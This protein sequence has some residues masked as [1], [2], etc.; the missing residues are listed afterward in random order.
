MLLNVHR[1]TVVNKKKI[2]FL[3][4][5][6]QTIG[7]MLVPPRKFFGDLNRGTKKYLL[8]DTCQIPEF[9][10]QI[11]R[12]ENPRGTSGKRSGTGTTGALLHV[13]IPVMI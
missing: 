7:E 13:W 3:C 4:L 8:G 11:P 10:S 12:P 1:K 5:E 6:W 9:P 2:T